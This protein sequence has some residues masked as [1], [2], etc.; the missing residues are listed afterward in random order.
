MPLEGRDDTIVFAFD[1]EPAFTQKIE[2]LVPAYIMAVFCELDLKFTHAQTRH[3][4]P[5]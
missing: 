2:Q 3:V 1:Q 4:L 5:D